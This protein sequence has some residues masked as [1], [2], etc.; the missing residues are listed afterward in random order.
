MKKDHEEKNI[1][2]KTI[3]GRTISLSPTEYAKIEKQIELSGE[4]LLLKEN[5][6][7]STPE[8]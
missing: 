4:R 3:K 6:P 7:F 8:K 5:P 2:Y 1:V